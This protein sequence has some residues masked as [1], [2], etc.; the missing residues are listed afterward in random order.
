MVRCGVGFDCYR[1][2]LT[3]CCRWLLL[4]SKTRRCGSNAS[5]IVRGVV[6]V[7]SIMERVPRGGVGCWGWNVRVAGGQDDRHTEREDDV[8]LACGFGRLSLFLARVFSSQ[9]FRG[10]FLQRSK[11]YVQPRHA[12]D[13]SAVV[14][15]RVARAAWDAVLQYGHTGSLPERWV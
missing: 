5:S 10:R 13:L 3:V 14:V 8:R 2:R 9:K 4:L 6:F 15:P 11:E 12:V 1:S 7:V